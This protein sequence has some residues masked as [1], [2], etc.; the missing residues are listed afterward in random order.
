MSELEEI[1]EEEKKADR[2]K[3]VYKGYNKKYDFRKFKIIHA[4][5]ND[6]RTN[7]INSDKANNEQNHLARYVK[8]FKSSTGPKYDSN[9]KTVE[10]KKEKWLFKAFDS[11]IFPR[12]KQPSKDVKYNSFGCVQT[13]QTL[14][15]HK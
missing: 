11:G 12:L 4:F 15:L 14:H 5:G 1:E 9:L 6:I 2:N 13:T 8:E 7:F 10:E 3:I